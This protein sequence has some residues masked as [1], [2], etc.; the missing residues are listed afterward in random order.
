MAKAKTLEHPKTLDLADALGIM[1]CFALGVMEAFWHHVAAYY[2]DGD[3]TNMK[4]SVMARSIRYSGNAEEL[5]EAMIAAG[6]VD[7]VD[8]RL[9]VHGWP[10]HCNDAVHMALARAHKHFADGTVPRTSRLS[11][12]E[13]ESIEEWFKAHPVRTESAQQEQTVRTESAPEAHEEPET[14]SFELC[15]QEAHAVRTTKPSQAII[16]LANASGAS[17]DDAD[18]NVIDLEAVRSEPSEPPEPEVIEAE[19]L[20]DSP[21]PLVERIMMAVAKATDQ[22]PP[23]PAMIRRHITPSSSIRRLVDFCGEA[24]ATKLVVWCAQFKDLGPPAVFS[25]AQSLLAEAEKAGWGPP[26]NGKHKGWGDP[27]DD[28]ANMVLAYEERKAAEQKIFGGSF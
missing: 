5:L 21:Y 8:G 14:A 22:P 26:K 20:S 3:I 12:K 19:V 24:K 16:T 4:P 27:A 23:T 9:L 18:G 25:N 1:D 17:D 6:F 13:R 7:R 10:E 15:A 28:V 11:S 2:M